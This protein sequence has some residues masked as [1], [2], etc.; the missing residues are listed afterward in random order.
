MCEAVSNVLPY[1]LQEDIGY[2]Y[3]D[4]LRQAAI[5]LHTDPRDNTLLL[6]SRA[7]LLQYWV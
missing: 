6:V 7:V 5:L 4:E 3:Q 2:P 1:V